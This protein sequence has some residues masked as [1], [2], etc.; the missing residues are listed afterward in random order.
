MYKIRRSLDGK[1]KVFFILAGTIDSV[2]SFDCPHEA[3]A[4]VNSQI[5]KYL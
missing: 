2:A 3:K 1:F 5:G 4:F